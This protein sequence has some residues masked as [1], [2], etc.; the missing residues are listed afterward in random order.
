MLVE[1]LVKTKKELKNLNKLEIQNIFTKSKLDKAC[2]Q[3]DMA[4]GDFK[5]LARRIASD[6]VLKDN[7]FNIVKNPIYDDIKEA[8]LL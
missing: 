7:L 4:Y 2:F 3:H 8:L 1:H 5:D 6:K